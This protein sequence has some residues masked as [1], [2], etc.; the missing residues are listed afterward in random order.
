MS[1]ASLLGCL[2]VLL[3]GT[4][5]RST[6]AAAPATQPSTERVVRLWEGDAPGAQGNQDKDVPT[7]TVY[8][9]P[10]GKNNGSAIVI[11]PGGGY[12]GL[13][14]HE[15]RPVADWLNTL[16]GTGVVLKYRLGPKYHH[17]VEMHDVQ[18]AIRMV[19]SHAQ[20]WS[21]DPH[22][23]GVLGFSAGGHLA[24]TAATH[25]DAGD[26]SAPDPVDKV[27]CRPDVAVLVYPVISMAPPYVHTG[28]RRNLLGDNPDEKLIELMSNEKQVTEKT[29]PVYIVHS[30][31]DHGVPI[32]NSFAFAMALSQ[33]RIPFAMRV[34]DHGGHG[35]GMGGN[36]PELS[37]WPKSCGMWLEHRGFFMP[38]GSSK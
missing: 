7:I 30:S 5:H 28:S 32:E 21:I 35:Y 9:A 29:P 33:Q 27:S 34:F 24:S 6:A 36:D 16:G 26:Q 12:G 25:F 31:D 13:A 17:P 15:G 8:P 18:R 38:T 4:A 20:E 14:P 37:T 10:Q 3:L 19:R 11:C 22:R 23:I 1:Q 2:A